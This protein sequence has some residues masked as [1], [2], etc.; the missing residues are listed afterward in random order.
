MVVPVALTMACVLFILTCILTERKEKN[1]NGHEPKKSE[2]S[3]EQMHD[4]RATRFRDWYTVSEC[5]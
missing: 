5:T 2:L 1:R 3:M 4:R